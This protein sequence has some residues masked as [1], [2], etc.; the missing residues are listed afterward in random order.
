MMNLLGQIRSEFWG[1]PPGS[2]QLYTALIVVFLIGVGMIVAFMNAPTRARKPIVW[3]ATFL[4]GLFYVV[5]YTWPDPINRQDNVLPNN[6]VEG[7]GFF[8]EDALPQ[9]ANIANILSAFLLGLG[10]FSLVR[11]HTLRVARGHKDAFFSGLL[12]ISMIAMVVL[13]YWD[14]WL[15]EF[16][17]DRAELFEPAN[18]GWVNYGQDLLFDGFLQQMDAAMF[19]L[20]AFYI[21]SAAY[22]AFRIRS[23]ESTVMMTSAL[24][25]MLALMGLADFYWN[26]MIDGITGND[27]NSLLNNF[28]LSSVKDWVQQNMQVPSLRALEFGVGLGA[29]AMGL[30][31]WLGLEKGGVTT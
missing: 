7:F 31:I 26:S 22:R 8:L 16:G 9:V 5:Y 10:I 18:W 19:S 11:M 4:A 13:G 12:L 2:S 29:L 17:P 14:W 6:A 23:I 3:T 1:L 20:I 24:I 27:A 21:L 15:K 30:R 25:L 28:K